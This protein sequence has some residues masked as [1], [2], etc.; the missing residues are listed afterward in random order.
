[1]R[2]YLLLQMAPLVLIPLLQWRRPR[3]ERLAFGAALGLYLL[4][5]FCEV[6]DHA[7]FDALGFV[8]GHTLKHLLASAAALPAWQ[9]A[10]RLEKDRRGE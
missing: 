2:P 9:L 8:S 3:R 7:I 6:A 4:A 10:R 5:K 1:M